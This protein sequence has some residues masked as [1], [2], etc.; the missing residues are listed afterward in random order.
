M[1]LRRL[2]CWLFV[3]LLRRQVSALGHGASRL[4]WRLSTL[5]ASVAR[6]LADLRELPAT[7]AELRARLQTLNSDVAATG[8]VALPQQKELLSTRAATLKAEVAAAARH[9]ADVLSA[10]AIFQ[11]CELDPLGQQAHRLTEDHTAIIQRLQYLSLWANGETT[12]PVLEVLIYF[13]VPIS[14]LEPIAG[15]LEEEYRTIQIPRLG[16]RAAQWW[17][18]K[19]VLKTIARYAAWACKR[20][21]IVITAV[22]LLRRIAHLLHP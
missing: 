14:H 13:F 15:D 16:P 3:L 17:Y 18:T 10:A 12:A 2:V 11:A 19:H 7:G 22:G 6:I 5:S 8:G 21:S 20:A 1:N 9:Q 4:Q